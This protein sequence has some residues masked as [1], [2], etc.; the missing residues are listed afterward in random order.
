MD[1]Y[2]GPILARKRREIARRHAHGALAAVAAEQVGGHEPR[3]RGA[4][5]VER[6]RRS[7]DTP[8]RVIAEIKMR[9]PS[10]GSIR[11]R[12]TG[13]VQAI[14]RDY[15]EGG[16][17]AVSVLCDGPGFGGSPLDVR[18]AATAVSAPVLFKEF[19]LDPVQVTLA[20]S[21][22]AH[23][24]LLLVRALDQR[25]LGELVQEVLRQRM[26]PVVE[27]ADDDELEIALATGATL[28]GVNARDLR[29]FRVDPE[30]ARRAIARIP[31]G[32]VAVHMS[33][34]VSGEDL[35]AVA[36]SRADAVLIG[37][38]LMRAPAPSARL[39][40]WLAACAGSAPPPR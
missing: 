35:R 27:A 31:S 10:A 26:A 13:L 18:R 39:R 29:T 33:G 15:V 8:P 1:D 22:G 9:S 12:S 36:A 3:D 34:I 5:A 24:V 2:L 16:A 11:P 32:R 38:A 14:A 7:G 4:I 20:R 6:L 37:E 23:M 28:I 25:A 30:R 17:A 40:E 19:V 21:V